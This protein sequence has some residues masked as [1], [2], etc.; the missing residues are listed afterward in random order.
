MLT[1]KDIQAKQFARGVRGYREDE[2]DTFLDMLTLDFDKLT[3]ENVKLRNE[4]AALETELERYK[5]AQ[6][7]V[8]KTMKQAQSLMDDIARSA[9]KRAEILVKNAELDSETIIRE[10]REKAQRLEDENKHIKQR[11][12]AFRDRY[13]D[14]LEQE[15]SHFESVQDNLFP[16]FEVDRLEEI[17]AEEFEPVPSD[18]SFDKEKTLGEKTLSSTIPSAGSTSSDTIVISQVDIMKEVSNAD[19]DDDRKTVVLNPEDLDV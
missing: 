10:A 17:L 2:V 7:E 15:L 12:I 5:G 11:Y 14:M 9:E 16:D 4:I 3:K 6:E 18:E 19:S 13:R 8:T 1:P